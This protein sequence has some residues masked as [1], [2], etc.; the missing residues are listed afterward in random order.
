M[1]SSGDPMFKTARM[2]KF[3][4]IFLQ[5]ARDDVVA[6]LHEAGV[7]QLKEISELEVAQKAIG[8]EIYDISSLLAKFREMREFLGPPLGKPVK[9]E[10]LPYGQTLK[11]AKKFLD[12]FEP[13]LNALK[14]KKEELDQKKQELL[15]Q[16][17]LLRSFREIK[18]P[19]SYLRSTDEI[20][21]VVGQIDEERVPEFSDAAREA[22]GRK[23]FVAVLGKGKRRILIVACR[24]GEQPKLSPVLYRHEVELLEI[25]PI[26]KPPRKALRTLEKRL[27]ELG[28]KQAELEGKRKRL[29]KTRAQEVSTLLELLEI[30]RE[31]LE[32]G[33]LFG[34]TDATVVMEGWV[35]VKQAAELDPLLSA[36]TNGRHV[37]RT[38]APQ[39]VEVE[40]VPVELE[41][42][43]VVEDFEYV[44]NMYGLPKYDEVDPTPFMTITF[45]MFFAIA[46][47]DAGYG[48]ALGLFMASGFWF[49]KIFPQKL[50]RMMIVCAIFTVIVGLLIGGWFGF[51]Q[52]F[53]VNP[54]QRPIPLLKLVIFIGIVHLI[55]A[56]GLA[57]V[58]KDIFRRDW[59]SIVLNRISRVMILIG[60][61]GL[62]FCILGIGM[63]EFGMDFAFPKMDL[64][65]AFNPLAPA[66]ATVV[67]FR[68]IFYLGLGIGM[69]GAVVVG[70]GLQEKV[71]GPVNVVYSITGLIADVTSYTRLLALGIATGVIAFS[72][73]FIIGFAWHGMM[74]AEL[75]PLSAIYAG[76]LLIG[77]AFIFIAAHCFNIFINS[78]GGFIHTMRLHFAEFFGK[79]Y[80]AGG[81]KFA[82]F[83]A[84]RMF[85][86]VK[87]GEWP[88][89]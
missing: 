36:A 33:G 2:Q 32:C 59:K 41:N 81:E 50:R 3:R 22:L 4:A 63:Y 17:E 28:G 25:P 16:M 47:S 72:I 31:R 43:K 77:F 38:Y 10:E 51:G 18:F 45:A 83:K 60:F 70:K 69:V 89:R 67:A 7:V 57:G 11:R 15:A 6:G 42:P 53:W 49:A 87:G 30:Q 29:A 39:K 66:A 76:L 46:L 88:G 61:F 8:E 79:F 26:P 85:T 54:I 34:Y 20:H 27:K 73:N 71:G 58:L 65:A 13:K 35:P 62:S 24:T 1:P 64:F 37:I 21:V 48:I 40:A 19:L 56:L 82:P 74:P 84:K 5:Q 14:A 9:T 52:G 44:T 75:T 68:I 78:L 55:V 12:R 86:K 80:E 23:V